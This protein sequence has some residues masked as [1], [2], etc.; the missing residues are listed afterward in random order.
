MLNDEWRRQEIN[1]NVIYTITNQTQYHV[2]FEQ[3]FF[4]SNWPFCRKT[5]SLIVHF[6]YLVNLSVKRTMNELFLQNCHFEN[7]L[8]KGNRVAGFICK[9]VYMSEASFHRHRAD[10]R[11]D[12]IL[13][14]I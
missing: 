8:F 2:F 4:I 11:V 13:L 12:G 14:L 10:R 7:K 1:S 6:F 3:K 9:T 5:F